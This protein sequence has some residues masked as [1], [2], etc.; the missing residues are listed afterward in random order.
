MSINAN[1]DE[2]DSDYGLDGQEEYA[3]ENEVEVALARQFGMTTE[4]FVHSDFKDSYM[5]FAHGP[6]GQ[7]YLLSR[8]TEDAALVDGH[9]YFLRTRRLSADGTWEIDPNPR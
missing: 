3:S 9:A 5:Y 1:G 4:R 8:L 2:L 6:D 7:R